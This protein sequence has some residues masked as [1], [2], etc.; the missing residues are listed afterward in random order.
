MSSTSA[1]YAYTNS[2][3]VYDS[4]GRARE[5]HK[6]ILEYEAPYFSL[7]SLNQV[8]EDQ[9]RSA[10]WYHV[11]E[12]KRRGYILKVGTKYVDLQDVEENWD[13]LQIRNLVKK[14]EKEAAKARKLKEIYQRK[15]EAAKEWFDDLRSE[16]SER[17][18]KKEIKELDQFER[19]IDFYQEKAEYHD[20]AAAALYRLYLGKR[21]VAASN[22]EKSC[23]P[24]AFRQTL[25]DNVK[26]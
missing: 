10:I 24:P 21:K 5:V 18:K 11:Q 4:R 26:A 13:P 12:L 6:A 15:K 22:S 23:N 3:E 17:R 25:P 16:L 14:L 20:R 2:G 7:Q 1:E 9:S 19:S 8:V